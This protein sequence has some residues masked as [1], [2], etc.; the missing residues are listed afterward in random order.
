MLSLISDNMTNSTQAH[1]EKV[2]I[3]AE[4]QGK[5]AV[6]G[7]TTG[8]QRSVEEWTRQAGTEDTLEV[9][10][11]TMGVEDKTYTDPDHPNITIKQYKPNLSIR[12]A[13]PFVPPEVFPF[14]V[15]MCPI[16]PGMIA[17]IYRENPDI[18]HTFQTFGS[19]DLAGFAA[20]HLLKR[21]GHD[22]H[23]VNTV[24]TEI[25]TYFAD[26]VKKMA[27]SLYQQMDE[28]G[29]RHVVRDAMER[30]LDA[31]AIGK[32][33]RGAT[34]AGWYALGKAFDVIGQ[35]DRFVNGISTVFRKALEWEIPFYLD[36]VDDITVS[37]KED[38]SRYGTSTDIWEVPLACDLN[39][40]RVYDPN[41]EEFVEKVH[42]AYGA[43]ELSEL[44]ERELTSLATSPKIA[45]K[46]TILYVGRLSD[47]KNIDLLINACDRLLEDPEVRDGV[48]FV[49]I[50]AGVD[51]QT[52]EDKFGDD[53][54][55]TGLVPNE[56]LPDVY[57]IIRQRN[58]FFVSASDT[59]TYG[60]THEEA[61]ACGVPLIAM[62]KGTRGH[63]Y[64]PGDLVGATELMRDQNIDAAV[65]DTTVGYCAERD[66][67]FPIGLLGLNG[68]IVPDYSGGMGLS[69]AGDTA[70]ELA[71]KD[72]T[73]VMGAMVR[74]P[75]TIMQIMSKYSAEFT[76]RSK[77]GWGGTWSLVQNVYAGD[78]EAYDG[79]Y[80]VRRH[81]TVPVQV[82]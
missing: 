8:F 31:R 29:F 3:C 35:R 72:L 67:S 17:D 80:S 57:N 61:A 56:L 48:H 45:G 40:F 34:A 65:G 39:K 24:M 70:R 25:D 30:K 74:L 52:I 58:G 23:L 47:E 4:Y 55:V 18:I 13:V 59:E 11:Y 77:M 26:Y 1:R 7:S 44:G 33:A 14:L 43:G 27:Q 81:A 41:L 12:D 75:D 82:I 73:T 15:D 79:A 32:L 76:Q 49:F 62:E 28:H 50:G 19:T 71:Q 37:R 51:A 66:G 63:L 46:R 78:S 5:G 64:F 10:V 20:G 36:R 38:V 60:I 2:V 54:T 53:V 22:V 21:N 68:A 6:E 69:K 9:I 42:A 16:H